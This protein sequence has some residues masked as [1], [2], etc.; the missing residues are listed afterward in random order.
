MKIMNRTI[1]LTTHLFRPL[2]L[3]GALLGIVATAAPAAD[4]KPA[5]DP[6]ADQLLR[7]LCDYLAEAQ[8]FSVSA[9]IWQ[10]IQLGSG[11]QVQVGPFVA[12]FAEDRVSFDSARDRRNP[13]PACRRRRSQSAATVRFST[14][15]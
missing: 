4:V 5:V 7:H 11:Q 1:N 15:C 6:Q 2:Y 10:D 12:G 8:L 14:G 13:P 9:E 3:I